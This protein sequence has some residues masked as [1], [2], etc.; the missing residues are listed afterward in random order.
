MRST[1][2]AGT[3]GMPGMPKKRDVRRMLLADGWERLPGKAS[4]HEQYKHHEKPGEV[5]L[6][7]K[8]NIELPEGTWKNIQRQ[9]GW[10]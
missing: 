8:E 2:T 6:S 4:G 1:D 10:K 3:V 9:A 7:G 5:T